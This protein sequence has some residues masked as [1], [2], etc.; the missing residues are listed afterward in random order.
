M[1]DPNY[2]NYWSDAEKRWYRMRYD[3]STAQ[4]VFH[5]WL[6]AQRHD[7]G[8][9]PQIQHLQSVSPVAT[10]SN[11]GSS[12]SRVGN[13]VE[14]SYN[15]QNSSTSMHFEALDS[16]YYVRDE[17]FFQE[18][19]VFAVLFTEA[20]GMNSAI[21][22]VTDYNTALSR[23]RYNELAY[24]QVRRFIIVR[25]RRGFCYAVPIFSYSNQ[26][27]KKRGVVPDEHA[28]AYSFGKQ[29]RLLEGEQRLSKESICIV[30]K[31]G[32]H[33]SRAS[34]IFFGIQHPIQYNVKVKDIGYVH[35]DWMPTFLGYWNQEHG[36]DTQ[37][38]ADVTEAAY[39]PNG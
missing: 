32:E 31:D 11:A 28:I 5:D 15:L 22:A 30:T 19:K 34:R 8:T 23:V 27:T 12:Y 6:P 25:R 20:A 29:P 35:P 38:P 7:S 33:L 13:W 2:H 3:Y 16:T 37:Q 21:N 1:G 24:T 4:W 10:S 26:G 36:N 39:N 14:G 9:H 18:G 17:A